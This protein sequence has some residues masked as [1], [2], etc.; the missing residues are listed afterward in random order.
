MMGSHT[1]HHFLK[2]KPDRTLMPRDVI[3]PL[4]PGRHRPLKAGDVV[5]LKLKGRQPE[6]SL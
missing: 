3:G 6:E 5:K 4:D 1:P 2:T